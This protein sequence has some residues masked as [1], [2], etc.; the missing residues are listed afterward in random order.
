MGH[1]GYSTQNA[2]QSRVTKGTQTNSIND[3]FKQN[4]ERKA[5]DSMKSQG[6]SLREA[7]DS[8]NHPNSFPI[9]LALDVTGSMHDI[10]QKLIQTGLPHLISGI[11]EGG[12]ESPALLFLAVGDH[13]SDREPL[14]ISQFESGDEELDQW[15]ERI[16]L[17]GNGGGNGGESYSL[18]HY[19]AARIAVTDS[20]EKRGVKGLLITIGDEPN[21]KDYPSAALKNITGNGDVSAF[22]DTEI[23]A[24]AQEKWE[25]YHINPRSNS[26]SSTDGYWG[27]ILGDKY[28]SV[29]DVSEIADT[30]KNIVLKM[31]DAIPG[32]TASTTSEE[33]K[34]EESKSDETPEFL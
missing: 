17:E 19:V 16:Y 6:I 28:I 30:V 33:V 11:I 4:T 21:H 3:N 5:H 14:Q 32:T 13:K 1:S 18:A 29:G 10:P 34:E 26:R 8:D 24:E 9:I 31:N 27:E 22:T 12:V 25:V 15:L 20:F 23:L 7:R 2:M